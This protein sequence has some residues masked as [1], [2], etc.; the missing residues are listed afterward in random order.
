[1]VWTGTLH[2]DVYVPRALLLE[3]SFVSRRLA[4]RI[5]STIVNPRPPSIPVGCDLLMHT[6][7]V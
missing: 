4:L 6:N 7:M 2:I 3:V 1:M 5:R